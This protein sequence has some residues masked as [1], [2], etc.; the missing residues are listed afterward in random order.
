MLL[1]C[2]TQ[3]ARK[4]GK[5][6]NGH[7]T[8]KGQFL[9]QPQKGNAKECSNY[10]TMTLISH[11]SKVMLKILVARLQQYMNRELPDVLAG[12]RKG[13]GTRGQ[14]ASIYLI[15]EKVREFQE[16]IYF[17]FIDYAKAFD[18]VDQKKLWKILKEMGIA[19]HLTCLLKICRQ[20]QE[21]TDNN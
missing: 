3:Y 17:C 16:N 9:F 8:G 4:F 14:I 11:A 6:N 15:I 21:A 12:F 20:L 7:K 13:R 5:L 1:K 10:G 19:D 2:C 18:C